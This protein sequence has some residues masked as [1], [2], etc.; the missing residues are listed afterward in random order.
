MF[1]G[2][3]INYDHVLSASWKLLLSSLLLLLLLLW[4]EDIIINDL[5]TLGDTRPHLYGFQF[6]RQAGRQLKPYRNGKENRRWSTT[7]TS[8]L[9]TVY[10]NNNN[11]FEFSSKFQS[12]HKIP[13][14]IKWQRHNKCHTLAPRCPLRLT[15]VSPGEFHS[16][17]SSLL[18][19]IF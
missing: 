14:D 16:C 10:N 1:Y 5:S 15:D 17:P 2:Y 19:R 12:P 13:S 3:P 7:P 9:I 8:L 6:R 4:R 18:V 11:N